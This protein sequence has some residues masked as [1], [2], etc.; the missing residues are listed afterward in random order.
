[1]KIFK[2]MHDSLFLLT[3]KFNENCYENLKIL[4][5]GFFICDQSEHDTKVNLPLYHS[6]LHEYL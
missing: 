4:V 2:D 5:A 3:F 6:G 1:M